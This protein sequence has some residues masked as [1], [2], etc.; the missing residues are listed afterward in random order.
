MTSDLIAFAMLQILKDIKTDME[1]AWSFT[2]P[3]K[4]CK[5]Q[6]DGGQGGNGKL[7]KPRH[8]LD[9]SK[10]FWTHGAWNHL[11]NDCKFKASG[12]QDNV[13]FQNRMG[14]CTDFCQVY[15]DE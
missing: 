13:T 10:Y 2:T 4:E 7:K 5:H 8:C 1:K 15:N 12:H 3:T 6:G 9:V 11:S 14:G